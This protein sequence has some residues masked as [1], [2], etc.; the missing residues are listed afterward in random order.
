M[1]LATAWPEDVVKPLL[2]HQASAAGLPQ[3]VPQFRQ[4]SRRCEPT[5]GLAKDWF[6]AWAAPASVMALMKSEA[7]AENNIDLFMAF[8]SLYPRLF[9]ICCVEA[10]IVLMSIS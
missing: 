7:V 6:S 2:T 3:P 10:V 4:R 5:F 1:L 8:S 9:Q